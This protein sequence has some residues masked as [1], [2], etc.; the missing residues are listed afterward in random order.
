MKKYLMFACLVMLLISQAHAQLSAWNGRKSAVV[1]SYDDALNVHLDKVIPLL[2]SLKLKGTFYLSG[3]FPGCRDRVKDWRLAASH[4]HELGNHTLF[5][6][7]LGNIPG[8]EWVNA[9]RKMENYS[10]PGMSEE[11]K[12]N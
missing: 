2:D 3:Y 6:P 9:E 10:L 11:I 8:R 12:M 5:H 1:L 7:C 4:G